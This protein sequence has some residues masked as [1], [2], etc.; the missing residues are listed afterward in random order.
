MR[1]GVTSSS[2]A[3]FILF[4]FINGRIRA[5]APRWA[6]S[7]ANIAPRRCVVNYKYQHTRVYACKLPWRLYPLVEH[8]PRK[9]IWLD[10]I[11]M[12]ALKVQ[13]VWTLGHTYARMRTYAYVK[14]VR[15][16]YEQCSAC[17]RTCAYTRAYVRRCRQQVWYES[18]LTPLWRFDLLISTIRFHDHLIS[19]MG[20]HYTQKDGLY[21]ETGLRGLIQ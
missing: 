14:I 21:T 11:S 5:Y 9:R 7:R 10:D 4:D 16:K 1:C 8:D 2:K 15:Q 18:T 6:T 3:G 12:P 17:A 20:N 19:I 13:L